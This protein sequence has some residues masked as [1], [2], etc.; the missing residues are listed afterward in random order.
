LRERESVFGVATLQLAY[1]SM[2]SIVVENFV[3]LKISEFQ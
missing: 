1:M 2:I 3:S